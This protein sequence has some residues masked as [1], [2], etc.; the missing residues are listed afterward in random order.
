MKKRLALLAG[1]GIGFVVGSYSGRSSYLKLRARFDEL[2]S[3]PRLREQVEHAGELIRDR[4][5][6]VAD[7]VRHAAASAV[8]AGKE[9]L[10]EVRKHADDHGVAGGGAADDAESGRIPSETVAASEHGD[11]LP[12][13]DPEHIP[14]AGEGEIAP[15][16]TVSD[17]ET[18]MEDEGP[19]PTGP[20]SEDSAS[21]DA[22]AEDS[23]SGR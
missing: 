2:V 21:E 4:A 17:P 1:L 18:P 6:E 11:A 22:S 9:K 20:G 16:D 12:D 23:A 5:P 8:S 15:D 14:P 3:D 19:A 10:E 13:L 7:G